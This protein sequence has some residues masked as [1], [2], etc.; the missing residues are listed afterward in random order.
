MLI[1]LIFGCRL[2]P[3]QCPEGTVLIQGGEYR[4]GLE[5]PFQKWHEAAKDITLENYCVDIYEFPNQKGTIPTYNVSWEEARD[6]CSGA[7]KR[8]CTSYEWER[9]CRGVEKWNYSYGPHLD[10][11]ICNTPI[12]GSGPGNNPP[13]I[14][15]SGTYENCHSPEGVYDLNG[16]MS[17]WVSDPWSEFAEPFNRNAV[18]NPETWRA[19]RGGTMWSNT[20]YGMDCSSRHGHRL[21]DWRNM[22]DGFRCCSDPS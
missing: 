10:R 13:P 2:T 18:S 4:I 11:T 20:F 9:A 8:L 19:L 14:E 15:P 22:D 1:I 5:E 17:E 3:L 16:S 6:M 12:H 7:K 21:S